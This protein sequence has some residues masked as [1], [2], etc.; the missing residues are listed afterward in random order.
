M[1]S[2]NAGMNRLRMAETKICNQE[3]DSLNDNEGKKTMPS[4]YDSQ[5]TKFLSKSFKIQIVKNDLM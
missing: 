1:M 3:K 5:Q 4:S 2:E